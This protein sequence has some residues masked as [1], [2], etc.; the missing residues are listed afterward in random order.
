MKRQFKEIDLRLGGKMNLIVAVDNDFGIGLDNK[1]LYNISA[2]ME[3]FKKKT[4]GKVVIM[5]DK[6]LFSLP[7][8]KPLKNRTNIV[9]SSD[10]NLKVENAIVLNNLQD[11]L[12]HIKLYTSDDVFVIGGAFVYKELLPYCK[13]AYITK[14]DAVR[15]A[16]KYFP[17]IDKLKNWKVVEKSPDYF[18]NGIKFNFIVYENKEVLQV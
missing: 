1:L 12:N 4:L 5:G 7:G 14:I 11:L 2:D 9:L 16:N 17:N 6:T 13:Y 10:K 8:S 15:T 18:E 3:F